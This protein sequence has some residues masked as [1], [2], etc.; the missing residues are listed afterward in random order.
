MASASCASWI[1]EK[2]D[3]EHLA[4]HAAELL[5]H[6]VVIGR[7]SCFDL[8]KLM[9]QPHLGQQA[10]GLLQILAG[11]AHLGNPLGG[12]LESVERSGRAQVTGFQRQNAG[13]IND[14]HQPAQLDVE[15][16]RCSPERS[17]TKRRKNESGGRL[18][19][20][21][22]IMNG[23]KPRSSCRACCRSSLS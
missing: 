7:L 15:A 9:I 10:I 22:R 23:R 4:L 14:R 17:S 18:R 6:D 3:F 21:L 2:N 16:G 1:I 5:G 12:R 8:A 19:S 11:L 13:Q 20:A